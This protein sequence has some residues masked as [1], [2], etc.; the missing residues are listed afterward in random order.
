MARYDDFDEDDP[1]RR[2]I[3][4]GLEDG[5]VGPPRDPGAIQASAQRGIGAEPSGAFDRTQFRNSWMSQGGRYGGDV[6]RFIRDNPSFAT[7]VT[8][9]S[10]NQ[11]GAYRFPTGE[12]LDLVGDKGGRNSAEWTGA[13]HQA[14][15]GGAIQPYAGDGSGRSGGRAGAA[16]TSSGG[17]AF[18]Q[19]IRQILLDRLSQLQQPVGIGDPALKG[20]S[21]AYRVS[22]ERGAAQERAQAAERAAFE[23]LNLGGQGSGSFN[24]DIQGI[25]EQAGQDIAAYDADLVGDDVRQRRAELQSLLRLAVDSGDAE[26]ARELQLAIAEMDD[27]LGRANLGQRRYEFDDTL[28]YRQG[29]DYEDDLYRDAILASMGINL[30][31]EE[32]A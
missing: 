7:G 14:A 26:S 2:R 22:R 6:D 12:V 15:L 3:E 16:G 10:G 19:Q 20:Q 5:P 32:G 25:R 18:Q 24:T 8:G 28:G 29:R 17:S 4:D 9:V 13:G 11:S 27:E 23:G 30:D 1:Y 31:R 21:D